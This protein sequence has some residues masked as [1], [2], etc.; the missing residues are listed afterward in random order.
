MTRSYR[1][2]I[3]PAR[4]LIADGERWRCAAVGLVEGAEERLWIGLGCAPRYLE[5]HHG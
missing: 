5:E 3:R 4:W 1:P 2:T